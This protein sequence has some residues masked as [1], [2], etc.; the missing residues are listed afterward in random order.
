MNQ[1]P[2]NLRQVMRGWKREQVLWI[3]VVL[4]GLLIL[5]VWYWRAQADRNAP[6]PPPTEI[7]T[8]TVT[9]SPSPSP[10]VTVSVMPTLEELPYEHTPSDID[11]VGPTQDLFPDTGGGGEGGDSGEDLLGTPTWFVRPFTT[12]TSTPQPPIFFV[13]TNTSRP[14]GT[15]A[16][17]RTSATLAPGPRGTATYV[18]YQTQIAKS[19]RP[20]HVAYSQNDGANPGI[21][22]IRSTPYPTPRNTGTATPGPIPVVRGPNLHV[23]DW[24]PD[25]QRLLYDDGATI[26]WQ[27]VKLN[28]NGG[29]AGA[30]VP[31]NGL[32]A[33]RNTEANWSPNG[34]W[35]VFRNENGAG[36]DLFR[37]RPDGTGLQRL[38]NDALDNRQPDWSNDSTRIVFIKGQVSSGQSDVY[39]ITVSPYTAAW[40]LPACPSLAYNGAGVLARPMPGP[41]PQEITATPTP[42][43]TETATLTPTP[44]DTETATLTPTVTETAT[45]TPSPTT[46][47]TPTR[48][49]T[50]TRTPTNTPPAPSANRLT[51]LDGEE[52]WPHLSRDGALLL[53]ANND[54]TRW[55]VY[56]RKMNE[57]YNIYPIPQTDPPAGANTTWPNWLR[58]ATR[59]MYVL[60]PDGSLDIYVQDGTGGYVRLSYDGG[61]KSNLYM[62][63]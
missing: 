22:M 60:G 5:A 54:G 19:P 46:S 38:T 59:F 16:T 57:A 2:D 52:G 20:P 43:E 34:G 4:A 42:T 51:F 45:V 32:P 28:T 8:G 58:D 10:S 40:S 33:G 18:A 12:R 13:R 48:T 3:A 14:L 31:L 17:P 41:L 50:R 55:R 9:P 56:V 7:L 37:V 6:P 47:L 63:P 61:S 49:P 62:R 53:F 15:S 24:S 36:S 29:A 11:I 21:W 35:I 39:S 30:P 26:Y 1:L 25:G 23:N 27:C 44:T